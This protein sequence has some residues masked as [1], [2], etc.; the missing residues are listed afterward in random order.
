MSRSENEVIA[1]TDFG[2]ADV[3]R[4]DKTVRRSVTIR[5]PLVEIEKVWKA[6]A[7]PG[8][9]T[10][11]EAPGDRGTEV[12]VE[13]PREAQSAIREIIGV[14][15]NDDP[16]E[17]LSTALRQFKARLETGEVPTTKGQPSGR[18]ALAD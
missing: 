2:T 15:K 17:S 7:I 8:I 14:L 13:A 9:A 5:R 1:E 10:F 6:A 12:R 3:H 16:G 18:E 4:D 11:S